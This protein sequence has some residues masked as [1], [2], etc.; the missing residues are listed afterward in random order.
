MQIKED[1][2]QQWE[3][4]FHTRCHIQ[5]KVCSMIIDE[6]SCTNVA[7]DTLMKKLNLICIKH[8]RTY[9]LQW[10][11]ECGEVKVTKQVSVAFAIEKYFDEVMCDVVLIHASH[12]LL[13]RPW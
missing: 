5:N 4:I 8:L 3:N 13:G 1:V 9:K 10:L 2:D 11:N 7:I 6:G 12:L